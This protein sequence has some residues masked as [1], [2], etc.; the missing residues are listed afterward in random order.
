MGETASKDNKVIVGAFEKNKTLI[1]E[2]IETYDPDV[3]IMGFP[4]ACETIVSQ[5]IDHLEPQ[6]LTSKHV[7]ACA[8]FSGKRRTYLWAYHPG[9]PGNGETYCEEILH[10]LEAAK[11]PSSEV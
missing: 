10:A 1:L 3:V 2:Q 7:G 6:S 11:V 4:E 5:V 9:K 8:Y